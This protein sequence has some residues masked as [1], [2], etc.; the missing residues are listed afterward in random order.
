MR[1]KVEITETEPTG[2]QAIRRE[3]VLDPKRL[4]LAAPAAL[5]RDATTKRVHHGVEVG[6][7]PQAEQRDVVAVV[8][9]D[10]DVVTELAQPEQKP[11]AAD[12]AGEHGDA[13]A[14]QSLCGATGTPT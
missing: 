14:S 2:F 3:L 11:R 7:D 5:G 8:A 13:H 10:R 12:A 4:R 6:A 9:D 1:G